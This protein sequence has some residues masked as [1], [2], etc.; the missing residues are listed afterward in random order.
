MFNL[1]CPVHENESWS[2]FWSRDICPGHGDQATSIKPTIR[3]SVWNL[4]F[5]EEGAGSRGKVAGMFLQTKSINE[6]SPDNL[7]YA[8]SMYTVTGMEIYSLKANF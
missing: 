8:M 4:T 1:D 7:M 2:M 5:L 6:S 3:G